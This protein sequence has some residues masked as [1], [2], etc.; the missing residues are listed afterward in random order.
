MFAIGHKGLQ[1][2][3]NNQGYQKARKG[4]YNKANKKGI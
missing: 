2:H 3:H 1:G 4:H